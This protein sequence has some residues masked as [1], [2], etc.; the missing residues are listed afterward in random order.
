MDDGVWRTIAGRR[1]F[2]KEGQS[3]TDA[4][5]ESGKFKKTPEKMN[6]RKNLIDKLK[7]QIDVDL[8]KSVTERQFAPRKGL[9]IDSRKLNQNEFSSVRSYLSKNN[10]RIESNGVFEWFITYQK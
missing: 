10:V 5:K 2:I 9:N 6:N 3:L 4:M 1:V 7:I 8:E